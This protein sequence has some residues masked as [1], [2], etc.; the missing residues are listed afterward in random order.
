M[1]LTG[2]YQPSPWAPVAE[3]VAAFEASG[4][5]EGNLMQ[6]VPV[7]VLWTT[8]RKSGKV[9]KTPLMRVEHDGSYAVIASKG[10]APTNP[11]WYHNI[12]NDPHV[13]L[14]D[15]P[16]AKDYLAHEAEGEEKARW[17]ARAV[18]VW[19][20]YDSY[21]AKTDRAIPLFVLDPA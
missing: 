12:A 15:G 20:A 10:G 9:R 16:E 6:G 2:E 19:P 1:P 13:T 14:Q 18:E 3:Q 11:V 17:W 5:S 7:I 8:G 4:G 21:Q